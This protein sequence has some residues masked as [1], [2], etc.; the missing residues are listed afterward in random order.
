MSF[1]AFHG[2]QYALDF[3]AILSRP[4]KELQSSF[5]RLGVC[6]HRFASANA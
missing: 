3:V 5:Y 6:T 1:E 4:P 2:P